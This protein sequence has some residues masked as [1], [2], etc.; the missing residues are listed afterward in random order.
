MCLTRMVWCDAG[1]F[2][3]FKTPLGGGF[4]DMREDSQF[5]PAM[6]LEA[7]GCRGLT[8]GLVIDLTKTDRSGVLFEEHSH[9]YSQCFLRFYDK[10]DL[11][12]KGVGH[13]KLKCEG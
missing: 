11:V 4:V 13:Y 7:V 12:S 6:L 8:M 5:S 9:N 1:K 3:P 2:L 10:A